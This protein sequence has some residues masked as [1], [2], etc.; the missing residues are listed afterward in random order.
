MYVGH[1][2]RGGLLSNPNPPKPRN[3]STAIAHVVCFAALG[4]HTNSSSIPD[5]AGIGATSM[6]FPSPPWMQKPNCSVYNCERACGKRLLDFG[7][8]FVSALT[9]SGPG[10]TQ[11]ASSKMEGV[12]SAALAMKMWNGTPLGVVNSWDSCRHIEIFT[13]VC[14]AKS[15]SSSTLRPKM[16][17]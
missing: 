7:V 3:Q 8:L 4:L 2:A 1:L 14:R 12:P 15:Q 5:L 17:S 9:S 6:R 11:G 10:L 16:Y 13:P